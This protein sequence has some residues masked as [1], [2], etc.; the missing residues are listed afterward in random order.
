MRMNRIVTAL[1]VFGALFILLGTACGGGG[2]N[3]RPVAITQTDDGCTPQT[4]EV[5]SGEKLTFKIQNQGKKDHEFEGINGTKVPEVEVPAGHSRSVDYTA[6][7][8]VGTSQQIKCYI[9]NGSTT[10]ITVTVG[11]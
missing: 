5:A 4:V 8:Q 9:P 2:G 3:G 6:P 1:L 7:K 11:S 10:L